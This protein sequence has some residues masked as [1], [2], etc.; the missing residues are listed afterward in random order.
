MGVVNKRKHT[1]QFK[2]DVAIKAIESK[3]MAEVAR[4]Y[5][6]NTGQVSKWVSYLKT[7]GSAI[8]STNPDKEKASLEGKVSKLEQIIGK[9]EVELSLIKNFINFPDSPS[10]K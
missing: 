1:S 6:L 9:K 3:Q 10:G 7:Q 4:L 2:F 8:F 5:G